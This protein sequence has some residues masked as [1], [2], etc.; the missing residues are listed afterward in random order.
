M[1]ITRRSFI[2]GGITVL[3]AATLGGVPRDT[4]ASLDTK[5]AKAFLID[6]TK[7]D[8]CKKRETPLCVKA[9]RE[10]N[11]EKF[12]EPVEEI[13]AVFPT[14]TETDWSDKKDVIKR[15]TPYNW[16]FVQRVEVEGKGP[17]FI[18]RRC[19]HCDTPP[20][21]NLCPWAVIQKKPEG[22]V[23]INEN[24]CLGGA[25]CK[26][27]CPWH[28]PQRQSGVGIY[29]KIL[30]NLIGNGVMYKC[31]MCADR[32]KSGLTPSCVDACPNQAMIFGPREEIVKLAHQRKREIN[33]Y[34]YGEKE[35]GGTSTIYLSSIPFEE[36]NKA[37]KPKDGNPGMAKMR[38]PLDNANRLAKVLFAVPFAGAIGALGLVFGGKKRDKTIEKEVM[39]EDLLEEKIDE[40]KEKPMPQSEKEDPQKVMKEEDAK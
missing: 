26:T 11:K 33:G 12:P 39:D 13:P 4:S 37:I 35:N 27:V 32:I 19:M 20:C 31:D 7:C 22:S 21:V 10:T 6:L 28:I 15:L 16:L 23:V 38:N 17:A 40:D 34:L 2:K 29:M 18:P 30:P 8:G 24:T 1:E 9:C 14:R 25:K 5:R 36:I 3:G